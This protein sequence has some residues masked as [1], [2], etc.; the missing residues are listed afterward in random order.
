MIKG[1]NGQ[2]VTLVG[3]LHMAE[4]VGVEVVTVHGDDMDGH[5]LALDRAQRTIEYLQSVPAAGEEG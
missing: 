3:R 2:H 1:L 4:Q 5:D